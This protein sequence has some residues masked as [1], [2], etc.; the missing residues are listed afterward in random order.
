MKKLIFTAIIISA[1]AFAG[2]KT[3]APETNKETV[4]S[5]VQ[6]TEEILKTDG[7][8]FKVEFKTNPQTVK[9]N[10]PAELA[11]TVKNTKDETVKDFQIVHEKPMHLLVVSEDL[12]EFYHLHPEAQTDG[13]YK[14]SFTFPNGGSYRLYTDFT[15]L[16]NAQVVQNFPLQVSG[17]ARAKVE[18][19]PDAKLEKNVGGLRVVMK[20]DGDLTA[21]KELMLNFQLFDAA[22]NKPV[23]DLE[24]YLGA[25][26]HFVVISEDLEQFV[27][28]HPM[29]NDNVKEHSHGKMEGMQTAE[30]KPHAHDEKLN[31]AAGE[32]IVS[33]H[34]SFPK[35]GV[36][37]IFA[38]FQRAGQVITVPFVV[39]I[40]PG[41][42]EKPIDLSGVEFP[43]DAYKIIVSKDGFTPS[44]IEYKQGVPLKLAF[45]RADKENCADEIV[46]KK[47][48]I[49]KKLPVGQ[50]VLIDIPT[51]ASGEYSFACGMDMMKGKIIVQ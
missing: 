32:S 25:R 51:D 49:T 42:E 15:P 40:A 7:G 41:A 38:Q 27:H 39:G 10:E 5:D 50:I 46:F 19:K 23:T 28:A 16:N 17:N 35:T 47:L 24:N 30:E 45:Y 48:H 26:A 33:A 1:L 21:S 22:T 20:P 14:I 29:S 4:K 8:T 13:A 43:A 6:P 37:K 3:A 9:A 12:S 2:C 18:L 36:Y 11:F 31:G 44:E 34:V